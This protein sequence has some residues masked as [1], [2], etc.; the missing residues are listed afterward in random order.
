[1]DAQEAEALM[2]KLPL[3][4]PNCAPYH[5]SRNLCIV[6]GCDAYVLAW[7]EGT[8]WKHFLVRRTPAHHPYHPEGD[9]R[10]IH[11]CSYCWDD[12]GGRQAQL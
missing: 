6:C 1:M 2:G 9:H 12:I 7:V 10:V 8:T 4:C 11:I 5:W 3:K